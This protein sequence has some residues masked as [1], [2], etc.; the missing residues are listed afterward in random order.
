MSINFYNSKLS[1]LMPVMDWQS[2]LQY[3]TMK[4]ILIKENV[5]LVFFFSLNQNLQKYLKI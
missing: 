4:I 1:N 5:L 2:M 3:L